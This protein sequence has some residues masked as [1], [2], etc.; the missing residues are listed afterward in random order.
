MQTRVLYVTVAAAAVAAAAPAAGVLLPPGRGMH[1]A[2][3]FTDRRGYV[4]ISLQSAGRGH[5]KRE[6]SEININSKLCMP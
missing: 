6:E 2:Q 4:I 1:V 3:H 5:V